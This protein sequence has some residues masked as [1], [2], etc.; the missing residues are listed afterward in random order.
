M[1]QTGITSA[2]G[3][4]LESVWRTAPITVASGNANTIGKANSNP[5]RFFTTEPGGGLIG[6]STIVTPD[7]EI[8]GSVELERTIKVA[9]SYDGTIS[10]KCDGENLFYPLLGL[11][12]KDVQ[13]NIASSPVNITKN[14]FTPN[15]YFPSFTTE[16][17]FGDATYGR[18]STGVVLQSLELTFGQILMG[19]MSLL[20]YRQIPNNYK[21]GSNVDTDYLFDNTQ[22]LIP[23]QMGGNGTKTWARTASPTYI[24]VQQEQTNYLYQNGP[25]VF[26]NMLFGLAGGNFASAYITIDDV[27]QPN[28]KI[29]QGFTIN[30]SRRVDASMVAGSGYDPGACTGSQVMFGGNLNILFEDLSFQLAQLKHSKIGIN[31]QIVGVIPGGGTNAYLIDVYMPNCRFT[32]VDGPSIA[33]G[34]IIVGGAYRARRDPSLG[35]SCQITLQNTFDPTQLGGLYPLNQ[36]L[37]TS[38]P[39]SISDTTAYL[40]SAANVVAGDSITFTN[41]ATVETKVVSSVNYSTNVV[42]VSVAFTNAFTVANTTVTKLAANAPGGGNGWSNA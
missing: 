34:P 41:G 5:H 24:D 36:T 35:Y 11:F 38:H 4:A 17:I 31:F 8:D 7:N 3:M 21:N 28:A 20:P 16:E 9:S 15:K 40:T 30:G 33:D 14:V 18:V 29:L 12:G 19:R 6:R 25:F 32:S 2:I 27:A 42:T 37:A 10:F 26:A 13:T 39:V 1:A 22:R 23:N